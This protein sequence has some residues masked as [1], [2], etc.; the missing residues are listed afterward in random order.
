MAGQAQRFGL[1][2]DVPREHGFEPL[3]VEGAVPREL[4][5]TLYRTGPGLFGS[6]GRSYHHLFESD[7]AVSGVRFADGRAA[8]ALRVVESQGLA[9]E[10]AAGRPLYG[11]AAPRLRRIANTLGARVKNLANTN[12][13]AW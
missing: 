1:F 6:Y 12:V 4:A 8:G 3:R 11:S 10:R 5:G 13:L 2:R 7:G 9:E